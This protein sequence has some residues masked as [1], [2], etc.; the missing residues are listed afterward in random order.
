MDESYD[1]PWACGWQG[2]RES[3]GV[4]LIWHQKSNVYVFIKYV[5]T[6]AM[7]VLD[8]KNTAV[9]EISGACV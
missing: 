2:S 4:L 9:N 5:L 1:S 3:C 6:P 7:S 8:T